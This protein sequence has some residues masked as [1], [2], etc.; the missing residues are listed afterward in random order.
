MNRKI[1]VKSVRSQ[2]YEQIRE[3]ILDGVW[4]PGSS[5][6]LNKVA[7]DFGVSKTPLNEAV[8]KLLQEGLLSVKPRSGTF[9]SRLSTDEIAM[10]FEFRLVME[11]GAARAIASDFPK[12]KLDAL[13]AMDAQM[14]EAAQ[15]ITPDYRKRFL[16]LD[17]DFHNTIIAGSG[18]PIILEHY[19]QVNTL[20]YVSRGRG[21][22]R[23]EDYQ[24]GIKE[25]ADILKALEAKDVDWFCVACRR[26]VMSACEKLQAAVALSV[27]N[28]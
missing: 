20:S 18:N 17:E 10:T 3:M 23:A 6:D 22:L 27:Q 11:I 4:E 9:V 16:S 15:G 19:K 1:E 25:H 7:A 5:I 14:R 28:A 24:N 12:E 21:N 13:Y 26:H 2:V 8:Q